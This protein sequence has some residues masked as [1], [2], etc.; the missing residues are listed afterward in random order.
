MHAGGG[1]MKT[2]FR[3]TSASGSLSRRKRGIA[4]VLLAALLL[5]GCHASQPTS[6]PTG[7]TEAP[8]PTAITLFGS[9]VA[10][11]Q[12]HLAL[13]CDALFI[14]WLA[15]DGQRLAPDDAVFQ[16]D[17]AQWVRQSDQQMRR[18]QVMS[19]N[20]TVLQNQI[21]QFNLRIERW[22]ASSQ[23]DLESGLSI[24]ENL[25]R[26]TSQTRRNSYESA[27]FD[28]LSSIG[29]LSLHQTLVNLT[30][31]S[32]QVKN[33]ARPILVQ[34]LVDL[35]AAIDETNFQKKVLQQ[36]LLAAQAELDEITVQQAILDNWLAGKN[37]QNLGY[38]DREG[39]FIYTGS[40][41][42]LERGAVQDGVVLPAG[43]PVAAFTGLPVSMVS[44][45]VDEQL[46]PQVAIGA[47]VQIS[48]LYDRTVVWI[49]NVTFISEKAVIMNGETVIPVL[50]STD[51][52]L[53]GP[54]YTVIAKILP[55][56]P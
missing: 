33:L 34:W 55:V 47:T 35:K 27:F 8:G 43:Q 52:E 5:T 21:D 53:P 29:G 6:Q 3:T 37:Q 23:A 51:E 18:Q 48:P 42:L 16:I 19:A 56:A 54:G 50:V 1:S 11:R 24:L 4:A 40:A 49:G 15:R 31:D 22:Q 17:R 32:A 14:E 20:L 2:D 46:I 30:R 7:Q 36:Q 25:I 28:F 10:S 9:T 38:L 41:C 45:P 39:R 12:Q 13:P 44:I 26:T